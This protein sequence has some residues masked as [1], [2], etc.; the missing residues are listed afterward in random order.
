MTRRSA[1][2]LMLFV[3]WT[4]MLSAALGAA[5]DENWNHRLTSPGRPVVRCKFTSAKDSRATFQVLRVIYGDY[6]R[7]TVELD[8]S[9]IP[10]R[11]PRAG[12]VVLY[13]A[14][15]ARREGQPSSCWGYVWQNIDADEKEVARVI[16]VGENMAPASDPELLIM[17]LMNLPP[18][19][20]VRATLV[21]TDDKASYWKIAKVLLPKPGTAARSA[22]GLQSLGYLNSPKPP[23]PP[24]S[25][26][27]IPAAGQRI[28]VRLDA[29]KYRAETMV[30]Y[31]NPDKPGQASA[32]AIAAK[33][34]EIASKELSTG[35]EAILL[36]TDSG[37]LG[38]RPAYDAVVVIPPPSSAHGEIERAEKALFEAVDHYG[39]L[40]SL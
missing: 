36:L 25:A 38:D 16:C 7:E 10:L 19:L 1:A 20:A 3:C 11:A 22:N 33:F 8:T 21:S 23:F 15:A 6:K 2:R 32:A 29:W 12:E 14:E 30:R 24:P 4:F 27:P 26:A 35:R 37:R 18:N 13:L 5:N 31:S 9:R 28:V 34:K 17:Y 40:K 39:R